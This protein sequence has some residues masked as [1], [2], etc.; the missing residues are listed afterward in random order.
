MSSR[1][2]GPPQ[3]PEDGWATAAQ[4]TN[5]AGHMPRN[6][7]PALVIGLVLA[8]A[9]GGLA[10]I[11]L[12]YRPGGTGTSDVSA[13]ASGPPVA[14]FGGFGS[15]KIG[16]TEAEVLATGISAQKSHYE[17]CT[18]IGEVAGTKVW[19]ADG[20]GRVT[21]IDTSPGSKTDKG[22]GEGSSVAEIRTA[23]SDPRYTFDE[24]FVAGQ[25]LPGIN[26]YDGPKTDTNRRML[27][28]GLDDVGGAGS[29]S[30]G[31][32]GGWEGC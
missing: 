18:V 26:V 2:I 5:P 20:S 32:A 27:S 29:P 11:L 19:I 24:G 9:L 6:R 16:M 10:W 1:P 28:F 14:T 23:Y 12:V 13:A 21:G 8:L 7:T 17:G 15:I 30:I 3:Q 22:V 31:R 4:P 25:G